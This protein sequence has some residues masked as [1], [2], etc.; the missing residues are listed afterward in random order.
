MIRSPPIPRPLLPAGLVLLVSL[1][2][3][4]SSAPQLVRAV[5]P[6]LTALLAGLL[7]RRGNDAEREAHLA[8]EARAEAAEAKNAALVKAAGQMRHDLRGILSPALLTADRLTMSQDPV[9]RR[10]GE[11]MV[12]TVER[13]EERLRRDS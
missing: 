11:T 2:T 6:A 1:A 5:A 9:A 3:L 12:A 10:A 7:L 8:C 4:P 13:A